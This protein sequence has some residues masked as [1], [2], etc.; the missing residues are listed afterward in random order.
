MPGT[1][2]FFGVQRTS[3]GEVLRLRDDDAA[4][5]FGGLGHLQLLH[6]HAVVVEGQV[7]VF[8]DGR[9]ADER[10]VNGKGLVEDILLPVELHDLIDILRGR[11]VHFAALDPGVD[12]GTHPDPREHAGPSRGDVPPEIDDDTLWD[13]VRFNFILLDESADP[14][15]KAD[16]RA[17]PALNETLVAPA[18]DAPLRPVSGVAALHDVEALRMAC[19]E[20]TVFHGPGDFLG[21]AG[22]SHRP[23]GDR[24]SVFYKFRRFVGGD[25][26]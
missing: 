26:F 17:R 24:H 16:M 10:H 1:L 2:T 19:F 5:I 8:V 23:K 3:F 14:G 18:R 4:R 15:R 20:K 11:V 12:E 21:P 6:K 7:P 9:A 22:K 25:D 13:A